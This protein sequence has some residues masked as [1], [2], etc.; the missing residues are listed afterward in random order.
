[1]LLLGGDDTSPHVWL[2]P[3]PSG[4]DLGIDLWHVNLRSFDARHLAP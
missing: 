1:M 3:G 4:L 2:L